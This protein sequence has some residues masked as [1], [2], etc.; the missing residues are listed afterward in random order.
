MRQMADAVRRGDMLEDSRVSDL[1]HAKNREIGGQHR[2][3]DPGAA[4]VPGR[5]G[6]S[7]T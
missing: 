7:S 6:T 5:S 2:Q 1:M 4:Q 3:P